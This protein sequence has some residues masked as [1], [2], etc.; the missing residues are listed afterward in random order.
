MKKIKDMRL[1][2]KR[3]LSR[4]WHKQYAAAG[5]PQ[6]CFMK[7]SVFVCDN[8]WCLF[9]ALNPANAC[10]SFHQMDESGEACQE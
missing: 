3:E 6:A 5:V 9:V 8:C 10:F 1:E 4:E 2:R 7:C